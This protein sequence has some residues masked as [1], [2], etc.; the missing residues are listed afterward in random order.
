MA[1]PLQI[2]RYD[3]LIRR[4][5]GIVGEGAIVTNVL[6]DVFPTVELEDTTIELKTLAGWLPVFGA[7]SRAAAPAL[8][9]RAQLFNPA[10]SG[11]L[12]VVEDLYIQTTGSSLVNLGIGVTELT[13]LIVNTK[14][15]DSRFGTAARGVSQ[16]RTQDG[17]S[18][19]VANGR[20]QTEANVSFRVHAHGGIAVLAPGTGFECTNQTANETI[21][22][23]WFARERVAEQ[24]ELNF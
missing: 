1:S 15:R 4:A 11:K 17:G 9:S 20:I 7:T 22:T 12:L 3:R 8:L 13:T 10:G 14:P 23:T 2:T 5:T 19:P 24:S 16:T 21:R 6:P 18:P